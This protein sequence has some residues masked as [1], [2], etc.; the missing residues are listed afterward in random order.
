MPELRID[1]DW[2]DPRGARGSELRAT[3]AR[4]EIRVDGEPLT[5]V[6][7]RCSKSVRDYVYV[8][9]YP[10]AEWLAL[11]WW[12]LL[13]GSSR[14]NLRHSRE[15]FALPDVEMLSLGESVQLLWSPTPVD[16]WDVRF[17]E[18][19]SA[20]IP[21]ASLRS[22]LRGFVD[23][24]LTRLEQKGLGDTELRQEWSRI[25]EVTSEE[26]EFCRVAA[27]LGL[28]PFAVTE[29]QETAILQAHEKLAGRP[30]IE[31]E[32]FHAARVDQLSDQLDR[33]LEA[34]ARLAGQAGEGPGIARTRLSVDRSDAPWDQGYDLARRLRESLRLG[35]RRFRDFDDI[36][37]V[38]SSNGKPAFVEVPSDRLFDAL[39]LE[40]SPGQVRLALSSARKRDE[41]RSFTLCRA[42]AEVLVAD[43]IELHL[44]TPGQTERQKRNRAFAAEFLAP[45]SLLNSRL[46]GEVVGLDLVE[47]LAEEFAVS[48]MVIEHQL[49]NHRLARVRL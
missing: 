17:L 5:R 18:S 9:L 16:H 8:P 40:R 44:V 3:W 48:P 25:D 20:L 49:E 2:E 19:G 28:D 6:H 37:Q 36:L 26:E 27:A 45:A 32:F 43:D 34:E 12:Q 30:G 42:V 15:G 21:L 31:H 23:A 47:E 13:Y 1:F 24:V 11:H 38:F 35:D 22:C 7:D 33:L 46:S 14:R 10:V 29:D 41:S 4:L 39:A